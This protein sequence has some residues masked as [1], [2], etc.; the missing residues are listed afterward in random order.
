M[1][2]RQKRGLKKYYIINESYDKGDFGSFVR[3][4][5]K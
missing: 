1:N 3:K 4:E 5:S 2:I